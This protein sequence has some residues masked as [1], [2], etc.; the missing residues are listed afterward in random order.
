MFR[1]LNAS[2][3]SQVIKIQTTGVMTL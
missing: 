3:I 2:I 1:I